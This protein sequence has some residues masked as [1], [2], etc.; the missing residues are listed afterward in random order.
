MWWSI[1][2]RNGCVPFLELDS[3]TTQEKPAGLMFPSHALILVRQLP[4]CLPAKVC[5]IQ[6]PPQT[7]RIHTSPRSKI[8]GQEQ[9]IITRVTIWVAPAPGTALAPPSLII[10]QT[11]REE[12]GRVECALSV[13][14]IRRWKIGGAGHGSPSRN[15][16]PC[17]PAH[18]GSSEEFQNS[19][20]RKRHTSKTVHSPTI[21]LW[22][23]EPPAHT[24]PPEACLTAGRSLGAGVVECWGTG[25]VVWEVGAEWLCQN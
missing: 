3:G 1:W 23:S 7:S 21:P 8:P 12:A 13:M 15:V 16:T 10:T 14:F 2:A 20:Q 18:F 5:R 25:D 19:L 6:A 11:A 24:G 17:P 22:A 4:M 9:I